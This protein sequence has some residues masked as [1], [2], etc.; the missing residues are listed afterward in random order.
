MEYQTYESYDTFLL[1]QEV[2]EIP[3]NSF[4]FR[5]PDRRFSQPK[6]KWND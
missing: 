6:M 2:M 3:G 4:K 1:Y 5:L